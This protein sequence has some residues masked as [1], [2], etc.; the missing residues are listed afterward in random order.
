MNK[1]LLLLP[2]LLLLLGGAVFWYWS[3]REGETPEDRLLL[4]GNIDLR[5]VNLAFEVNGRIASMEVSEGAQVRA[6]DVLARLDDRR[7]TLAR[8][9]DAAQVE[10]QR[11]RLQELEAGT[12]PEE[13][14]KL[15]AELD[16]ARVEA[17]NARRNAARVRE[18]ERNQL[19][20][21]QQSDDSRTAAEAAQDKVK[22]L[23]AALALAKAGAREEEISAARATLTAL[24]AELA[25]AERNLQDSVL[26][27]P[28]DGIIQ[29]RILEPGDMASPQQPV[30]TLAKHHPL[31]ARVYVGETELGQVK[32]G[33]PARVA[34]DSFPGKQYTGWVGYIS[35]SAEFT[36][37]SV[38]TQ[39]VRTDLVYQA[40][41]FV[42]NPNN[43]LRLGMPVTVSL[44]LNTSPLT[45][46][47]C[48]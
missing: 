22:S 19:A 42:C 26:Q 16:A 39:E 40:R 12:R 3:G 43:E 15:E 33:M 31:W 28:A 8:A 38:Q 47:A 36:P 4:Y 21:P 41:V 46:P 48:D 14:H 10:A 9:A 35:P 6:G 24:Q 34:S 29:S 32:P 13:I 25:L 17:K 45:A 11:A 1:R 7:L 23:Q 30:F 2:L 20:S 5:L 18:L 44:D 27:A 37:K